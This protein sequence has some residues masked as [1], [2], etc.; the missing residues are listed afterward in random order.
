MDTSYIAEDEE[1]SETTIYDQS[2]GEFQ[3]DDEN[4]NAGGSTD[5]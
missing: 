1:P 5:C 4:N 2:D 3:H